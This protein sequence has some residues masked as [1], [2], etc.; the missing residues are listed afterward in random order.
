MEME[1]ANK[2]IREYG[3]MLVGEMS[4]VPQGD[5]FLIVTPMLNRHNDNMVVYVAEDGSGTYVIT[6][7]GETVD[8]LET[9][10][11]VLSG[12]RRERF[13]EILSGFGMSATDSE[14]WARASDSE[15]AMKLN[16]MMQAM[17]SVDDMYMLMRTSVRNMFKEDVGEWLLEKGARTVDSPMFRGKSGLVYQFPYAI[18]QS[19]DSPIRLVQ[20]V[21]SPTV[22][23]VKNMLFG[24]NDVKE[25]RSDAAGYVFL[26]A[27]DGN[28]IAPDVL[29]ACTAY[30]V[31][32]VQWGVNQDDFIG[33]L[34]A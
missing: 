18:A 11:F 24:W 3:E 19:K 34:T 4:A 1:R 29:G 25:A 10:G 26:N 30:D 22:N 7:M 23:N 9:D 33:A 15:L 27:S 16:F 28:E 5:G 31:V 2:L 32:P 21:G 20:T 6:D 12:T 13:D 14:I 8:D 17:A